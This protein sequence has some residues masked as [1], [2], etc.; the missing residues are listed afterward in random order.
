Y[1]IDYQNAMGEQS[2]VQVMAQKLAD[3]GN[4]VIYAI[5]TN[6]AQAVYATAEETGTP[7]VFNAVTDPVEAGLVESMDVPGKHATGV[8]DVAPIDIQ[9][10][11]IK[12]MLPDVENIGILYNTGE[13]NSRVQVAIAEEEA[14]KIGLTIVAQGVSNASEIETATVQLAENVDAIY[15]ITDN[16]V[17]TATAQVT[18]IASDANV[19]VFAAEVGQLDQGILATDSIDYHNLGRLGGAIVVDI[20]VNGT[21]PADIPVKTVTETVLYINRDVAESLGITLS[22][23]ILERA[24][25]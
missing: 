23:A 25:Q 8:S 17:V 24:Q 3:D 20:L 7:V 21:N 15:N 18:S 5:A 10:A 19:P 2:N 12:E 11:L 13:A 4:D 6:A 22:D 9:L 1:V 16:M 14:A